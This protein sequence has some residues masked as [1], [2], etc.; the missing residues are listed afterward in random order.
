MVDS[1]AVSAFSVSSE[2]PGA[3]DIELEV[4]VVSTAYR[5][6]L[7]ASDSAICCDFLSVQMLSGTVLSDNPPTNIIDSQTNINTIADLSTIANNYASGSIEIQLTGLKNA[8][9]MGN[10]LVL[11]TENS[12]CALEFNLTAEAGNALNI[13]YSLSSLFNETVKYFDD[14]CNKVQVSQNG[15]VRW[16]SLDN[17]MALEP[18]GPNELCISFNG[19][20]DFCTDTGA[21]VVYVTSS[22]NE[23]V[24]NKAFGY[25]LDGYDNLVIV[26][27][28]KLY[29]SNAY[30]ELI[31]DVQCAD[32]IAKMVDDQGLVYMLSSTVDEG[33]SVV[34]QTV[35]QLSG[36][37]PDLQSVAFYDGKVDD[38]FR[39][40]GYSYVISGG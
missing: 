3:P 12:I 33:G 24:F 19:D 32:N 23:C 11:N 36:T 39:D 40:V 31:R 20:V 30:Q 7:T 10:Q 13:D 25:N 34:S 15:V 21:F 37:T 29:A 8:I 22:E 2:V 14:V 26:S 6:S 38:F 17:P 27:S 5:Y 1:T 4:D 9:L 16:Y 35:V 28:G 18:N